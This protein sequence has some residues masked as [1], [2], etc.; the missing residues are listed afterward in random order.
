[1]VKVKVRTLDI[2]LLHETSPQKRSDMTRV[3]KGSRSFTCAPTP[4]SAIGMS[5]TCICLTGCSWYS[6]ADPGGMEG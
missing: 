5:H 4:S 1:M 6:F 2:A 3:L